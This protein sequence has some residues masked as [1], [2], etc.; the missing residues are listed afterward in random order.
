MGTGMGVARP[1]L[2][3]VFMVVRL[4]ARSSPRSIDRGLAVA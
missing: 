2:A 4:L 3:L 1:L